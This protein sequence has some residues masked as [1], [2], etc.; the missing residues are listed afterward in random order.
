MGFS[1]GRKNSQG[2]P[3]RSRYQQ[4]LSVLTSNALNLPL[5]QTHL[6]QLQQ[7][8]LL[9]QQNETELQRA[10]TLQQLIWERNRRKERHRRRN[11]K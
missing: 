11:Q 5:T 3:T 10:K 2:N 8:Y 6:N 7:Y 1:N 4:P 9:Q